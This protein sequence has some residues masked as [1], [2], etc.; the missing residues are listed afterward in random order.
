VKFLGVTPVLRMFDEQ[1]ARQFYVEWLGFHVDFEH[2]FE[3]NTPLYLGL[4][5]GDI[6]LHL[7]E[8]H[9]D[10]SPGAN[11]R[12]EC[13]DLDGFHKELSHKGYKFYR[14]AIRDTEWGTREMRVQDG[15]GN[16]ITFWV[17]KPT[18]PVS[19]E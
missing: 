11:V 10:G 19:P 12:I 1:K 18:A 2:R 7:S 4:S 15:F 8:H 16:S 17:P 6:Q 5:L 14:P 13:D 3:A 9:G